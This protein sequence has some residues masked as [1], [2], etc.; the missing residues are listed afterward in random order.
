MVSSAP[1]LHRRPLISLAC[2]P[3]SPH[4]TWHWQVP[5]RPIHEIALY[6]SVLYSETKTAS[7]L[8]SLE[9]SFKK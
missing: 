1:N 2:V 4:L 7:S 6:L 8:N 3:T 9:E 5:Y